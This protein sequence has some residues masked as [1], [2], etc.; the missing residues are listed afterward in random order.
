MTPRMYLFDIDGTVA[1][2]E[3]GEL[4]PGVEEFFEN[5][6][7]GTAVALVTNQ[8][9]PAC[10]DAGWAYSSNFPPLSKVEAQYAAI[11][12]KL[13]CGDRLYMCLAHQLK[14]GRWIYPAGLSDG[15]PRLDHEW[16]KP[17]HGMLIKAMADAGGID[18]KH[19]MMVGDR[20]EDREAARTAGVWF[21]DAD[22][23]F[24]RE[25]EGDDK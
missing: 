15:D 22:V 24:G 20:P 14:D 11:A 1:N 3:T 2:R 8:G 18:P 5:L 13:G 9:G 16:R 17:R 25:P 19:V 21:T 7:E 12:K 4:L 23:F 6:P 10:H